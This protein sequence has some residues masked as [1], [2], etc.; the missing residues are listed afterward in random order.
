MD[1][2]LYIRGLSKIQA[3]N[4]SVQAFHTKWNEVLSVDRPTDSILESL[5]KMEI[6]KSIEK[7]VASQRS[8][9]D[10]RR[11]DTPRLQIEI[12]GPKTS[13]AETR[14]RDED[15]HATGAPRKGKA[16]GKGK[17]NAKNNSES[18][19]CTRWTTKGQCSCAEACAFKHDP[20]KKGEG[21]GRPRSLS[22]TGQPHRNSKRDGKC[23]DHGSAEG[24]PKFT[25]KSPS[26]SEQTTLYKLQERKLPKVNFMQ[27][28]ACSRMCKKSILQPDTSSET[29]VFTNAQLNLLVKRKISN[30]CKSHYGE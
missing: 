28:L 15:R 13:R 29:S 14:N 11:Q 2:I 24:T 7:S 25:G 10:I 30:K 3:K 21:K 18:R 26:E 17:W 16:K 27:F 22:P 20:N 6:E 9:D 5:Y 8:R 4:A 12:N 23:S 19:D 1:A